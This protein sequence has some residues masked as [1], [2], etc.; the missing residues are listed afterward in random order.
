MK[1]LVSILIPAYNSEEWIGDAIRSALAQTW[2]RKEIMVV[3]DG[4]TDQTAEV[5]RR[6]AAKGVA[7]VSKENHGPAPA[8]N[9]ALQLSQGDYIQWLDADDLLAP[10]KTEWQ[11][12]MRRGRGRQA[13]S[14]L[15]VVG[16]L[17]L[18]NPPRNDSSSRCVGRPLS[19]R[20]ARQQASKYLGCC[21]LPCFAGSET[22][23][24]I[25]LCN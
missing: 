16:P 2:R 13:N 3:D 21:F 7:V 25:A 4:S 17:E 11:H 10:D 19:R 9:H 24:A 8:R 12:A 5:A 14:S 1:P 18:L 23:Y 15:L 20:Q 22:Y 6:F